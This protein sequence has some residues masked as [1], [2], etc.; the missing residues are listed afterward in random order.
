MTAAHPA[1]TRRALLLSAAAAAAL[2]AAPRPAAAAEDPVYSDWRGRAIKG[3]D[4]VAYHTEGKPVPGSADITHE[5]NDATWR[6]A[7]EENRA[8]FQAD[9][10]RYA[11][12]FGGYC[13]WAV[14]KGY[15][16][17][18]DP[19]AWSVVEGKLYLNYSKSVRKQWEADRPAAIARAEANWPKVLE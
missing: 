10:A 17:S 9:P 13:A 4:P 3:Y 2:L 19:E 14:S 8:L 18:V 6:F 16:A 5:W 7:S 11:P 15:T 1:P 12:Q